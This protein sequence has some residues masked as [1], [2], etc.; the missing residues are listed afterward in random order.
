MKT[1]SH[2]S[3]AALKRESYTLVKQSIVLLII[4][5]KKIVINT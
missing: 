3:I 5:L 1:I 4:D 2:K